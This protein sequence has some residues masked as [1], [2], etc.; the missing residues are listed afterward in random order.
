MV[1]SLF[2]VDGT[3]EKSLQPQKLLTFAVAREGHGQDWREARG[4]VSSTE[5]S[6]RHIWRG[7]REERG[8]EKSLCLLSSPVC[9][10]C[11]LN[12]LSVGENSRGNEQLNVR[13]C[14]PRRLALERV[15]LSPWR[16]GPPAATVAR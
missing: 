10:V 13:L 14:S 5:K 9:R 12:I 4:S 11:L 1:C 3:D 16:R 2:A 7:V 6:R 15:L 8:D